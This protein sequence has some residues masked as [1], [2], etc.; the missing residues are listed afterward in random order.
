MAKAI[1]TFIFLFVFLYAG[2]EL[3]R[4]MTQSEKWSMIKTVCYAAGV[5]GLSVLL[6]TGFVMLF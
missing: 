5:S 1:I 6:L 2:I 4:S 3:V